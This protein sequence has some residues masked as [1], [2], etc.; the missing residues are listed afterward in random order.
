MGSGHDKSEN[1]ENTLPTP[2]ILPELDIT[3][4][5]VTYDG[6]QDVELTVDGVEGL[7]MT[8]KAGSMSRA[9][10]SVPTPSDP[11][12]LS[13]DQVH[14]DDVPMPMPDG[15]SP[16]F[17]WTL[18]PAGATFD[19][20]IEI[21]Y[22][23]MTGLPAGSISYFLSFNHDTNRF[24][25]VA[26][27]RVSTDGSTIISDPGVGITVAGWGC[28]CPPY[29]VAGA[30][31]NCAVDCLETG[32]L[33][34]G[35]GAVD[36]SLVCVGESVTFSVITDSV[37]NGGIKQFLCSESTVTDFDGPVAPTYSWV[38][39]GPGNPVSGNGNT[40]TFTPSTNGTYSCQFTA[41][42][43]RDC[44]PDPVT[45]NGG[46]VTVA[47]VT[48]ITSSE[49]VVC[50]DKSVTFTANGGPF[51][52][53]KP[54]WTGSGSPANGSGALFTTSW[55]T[56]GNKIVTA[57]CL[58]SGLSTTIKVVEVGAMT[59]K[60]IT[61]TAQTAANAEEVVVCLGPPGATI[62]I[63]AIPNPNPFPSGELEWSTGES[64][65]TSID[66]PIDVAGTFPVSASCNTSTRHIKIIPVDVKIETDDLFCVNQP[67]VTASITGVPAGV[68]VNLVS[69][70]PSK[71]QSSQTSI[72]G[73][74]SVG[75]VIGSQ[76]SNSIEDITLSIKLPDG[77]SCF[78]KKITVFHIESNSGVL[79][80]NETQSFLSDYQPL[81]PPDYVAEIA[82]FTNSLSFDTVKVSDGTP[83]SGVI[84]SFNFFEDS[85]QLKIEVTAGANPDDVL[86]RFKQSGIQLH[87]E[88][89]TTQKVESVQYQL[90]GIWLD[91]PTG[92][93][94]DICKGS[95][96]AFR[97]VP[98][99]NGSSWPNGQPVWGG[100]A[101]GTGEITTVAFSN[102]GNR[103]VTVGCGSPTVTIPVAVDDENTSTP[104][105][106][107]PANYFADDIDASSEFEEKPF[108]L[109]Y[110]ACAD[111]NNNIW[112]L[113]VKEITGDGIITVHR[114]ASRDPFIDPP[115]TEV[116]AQDAVNVMKD[117]HTNGFRGNWHTEAASQ[118]HEEYHYL[119]WQ[120]ASNHYWS[121]TEVAIENITIPYDQFPVKT[122]AVLSMRIGPNGADTI[123]PSFFTVT[124]IYTSTLPD[125]GGDR[126]FAAGQL[127]LNKAIQSVQSLA[128]QN[129]WTVEQG[130]D[131]PS[132][133]NP[134][135]VQP[136]PPF[137][138]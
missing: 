7:K 39:S 3:N 117:Y 25:I 100:D 52:V 97:A 131:N 91:V 2:V 13:L 73:S 35:E 21:E 136:F 55:S 98:A 124:A 66:F 63:T 69:T 58:G 29:A 106:W 103:T 127:T 22:P 65:V 78:E 112:K 54:T 64:G 41:T 135:H 12:I 26:T 105:T 62:P 75:L 46:S 53:G 114:G 101:I 107:D 137:N 59:A 38:I 89:M 34:E 104:I 61:S 84:N 74:G 72:T 85:G 126:P 134:C 6:T 86:M 99:P 32:S 87:Q 94:T 122:T 48:S 5:V 27:G 111:I 116:E 71:V 121:A 68:T 31:I 45:F 57:K 20:P 83:V 90:N 110:S 42:A 88:H 9:D 81:G 93:F 11:A 30:C 109:E 95:S 129:N 19:P 37:D 47:E 108:S 130:V 15:V 132:I 51:P 50:V 18:Q 76:P 77:S 67:N 113:R 28:N 8:V 16:P 96:I 102:S 70:K 79:C 80:V 14:H 36:K 33:S 17:A 133:D 4:A 115:T 128:V 43:N 120:C 125:S 123:I 60:G 49:N 56:P 92:G 118:A 40:V 119:E 23:N 44:P 24:E 1:A 138:P 10:G 82:A